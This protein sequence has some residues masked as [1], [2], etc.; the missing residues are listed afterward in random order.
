MQE[1]QCN[2]LHIVMHYK[3]A[4]A[5]NVFALVYFQLLILL[6]PSAP[7]LFQAPSSVT[8]SVSALTN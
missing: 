1:N 7:N 2:A 4:D 8:D 5:I 3:T 6:C